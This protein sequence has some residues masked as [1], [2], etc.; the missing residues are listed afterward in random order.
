[1]ICCVVEDN[2]VGI[3]KDIAKQKEKEEKEYRPSG[4]GITRTRIDLLN[5]AQKS[6]ASLYM[7]PLNEGTRVE[8]NLPLELTF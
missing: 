1:M 7:Y 3:K 5:R 4:I 6:K 8:I 2:G